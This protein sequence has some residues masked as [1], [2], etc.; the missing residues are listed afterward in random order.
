M[1]IQS[2]EKLKADFVAQLEGNNAKRAQILKDLKEI[3]TSSQQLHGAIAALNIV[4][5]QAAEEESVKLAETDKEK[6]APAAESSADA[7]P[8]ASVEA[9]AS[10]DVAAETSAGGSN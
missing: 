3:D 7:A 8:A 2:I 9:T 10:G 6:A 1:N 4:S 5:A